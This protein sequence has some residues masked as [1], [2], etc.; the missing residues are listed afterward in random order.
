MIQEVPNM[1]LVVR[2][3]TTAIYLLTNIF[4]L[5]HL[6]VSTGWHAVGITQS[7]L[8]LHLQ[9]D[10]MISMIQNWPLHISSTI[11]VH[12]DQRAPLLPLGQRI[13]PAWKVK[14]HITIWR[15]DFIDCSLLYSSQ[16]TF[17]SYSLFEWGGEC[18]GILGF[19]YN[20]QSPM[21]LDLDPLS[22]QPFMALEAT[23]GLWP[24][25]LQQQDH[26]QTRWSL[27]VIHIILSTDETLKKNYI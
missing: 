8:H 19:N 21:G 9:M 20:W 14:S 11:F 26:N 1:L 7:F 2:A 15:H 4:A 18:F 16:F 13:W 10:R 6:A 12:N 24:C 27:S 25:R 23:V 3:N 17:T 22:K 5:S